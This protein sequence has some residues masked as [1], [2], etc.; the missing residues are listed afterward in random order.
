[1]PCP[2]VSCSGSGRWPRP[3]PSTPGCT[4]RSTAP[5]PR[6]P[7]GFALAVGPRHPWFAGELACW[8]WR[9][10]ALPE[11]PA[12]VAEP[13]RLLLAGDWRAAGP[14][15]AGAGLPLRA[16]AGARPR[17]RGGVAGGAGAAGRPGGPAAG[18]AAAAPAPAPRH[19][20]RPPRPD[21]GHGRQPGR[22]HRPA[23]RG[24]RAARPGPQQRRDRRPAVAVGQDGRAPR[25]GAAGQ[26][27]G[28]VATPGRRGRPPARGRPRP[29]SRGPGAQ[30]WGQPPD[31]RPGPRHRVTPDGPTAGRDGG[32]NAMV[33]G[34]GGRGPGRPGV[35]GPG[36]QPATR[37]WP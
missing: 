37:R 9:A 3:A 28:R 7:R 34:E 32:R 10:G 26:A 5:R 13:Y 20:A 19:P 17:R 16:G 2:P 30:N 15:L 4:A 24:A 22:P 21:P 25:L 11:V 1:M 14:R 23:G 6:P 36:G 31:P 29:K 18:P 8:L 27:R 33:D 35:P 12:V